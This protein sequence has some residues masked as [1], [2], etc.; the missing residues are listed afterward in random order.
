MG[1]EGFTT[2]LGAFRTETVSPFNRN[3]DKLIAMTEDFTV[4]TMAVAVGNA[5]RDRKE[6]MT[7]DER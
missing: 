7:L 4:D 1:L 6:V 3:E 5:K 2:D